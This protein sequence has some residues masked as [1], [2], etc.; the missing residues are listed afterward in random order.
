MKM[1][2]W[3]YS[4]LTNY[5]TCP[6]KYYMTKVAKEVSDP[7]GEAA[8]WGTKVHK[9]IEDYIKMGKLMPEGMEKIQRI[10]AVIRAPKSGG[11]PF[12]E[13]ELA[14]T[15]Q[16]TPTSWKASNAWCRG[17]VDAGVVTNDKIM[18]IDWKTGNRKPGSTQLF[19][20]A[21]MLMVYYPDVQ[22]VNSAFVW[23]KEF[24]HDKETL[25]REDLHT[26]W[27]EF[28]PRV[29]R[30]KRAFELD[31]WEPKPSGLCKGWCPCKKCEYNGRR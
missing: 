4:S 1:P 23:L 8:L 14:I 22:V 30:M 7:P 19:L 15:E 18:S 16:F 13:K 9:H 20:S 26:V 6:R 12:A 10:A 5:E 2:P 17:I 21:A 28:L 29:E 3:S 24:R 31:K 11:M 27:G 25:L